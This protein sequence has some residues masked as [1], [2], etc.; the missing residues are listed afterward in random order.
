MANER[1]KGKDVVLTLLV[2][3]AEKDTIGYAKSIDAD[4]KITLESE[5]YLGQSAPL[6]N[7]DF[8]GADVSISDIHFVNHDYFDLL[9]I[10]VRRAK[11]N[12]SSEKIDITANFTI[13]GVT[14]TVSFNDCKFNSPKVSARERKSYVTGSISAHSDDVSFL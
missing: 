7:E 10:L 11:D 9:E 3:G 8:E 2:D 14:R 5:N 13:G 1:M 4:F 6:S 12:V